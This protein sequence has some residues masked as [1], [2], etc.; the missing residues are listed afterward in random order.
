MLEVYVNMLRKENNMEITVRKSKKTSD[1]YIEDVEPGYV[2]EILDS[3]F[4]AERKVKAL[5][6]RDSI[7]LL[8]YS[9][10]NDW[11]ELLD[12]DSWERSKVKILGKLTEIIV[13]N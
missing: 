11:L 7:V 1:L 3:G 13:E 5:K 9:A 8:K 12:D 2:F 4:W 6:L 10:G